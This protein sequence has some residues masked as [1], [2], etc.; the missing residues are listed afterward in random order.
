MHALRGSN[1]EAKVVR[2]LSQEANIILDRRVSHSS[3][4]VSVAADCCASRTSHGETHGAECST[5]PV[6]EREKLGRDWQAEAHTPTA[7]FS[8]RQIKR[9]E[10]ASQGRRRR[11]AGR[12]ARQSRAR[13]IDRSTRNTIRPRG[14]RLRTRDAEVR[15]I[16]TTADVMVV[17]ADG[18]KPV[19]AQ[20]R[21]EELTASILDTGGAVEPCA[22]EEQDHPRLGLGPFGQDPDDD[23]QGAPEDPIRTPTRTH[24]PGNRNSGALTMSHPYQPARLFIWPTHAL[25]CPSQPDR[26]LS[27][28]RSVGQKVDIR[29]LRLKHVEPS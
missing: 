2:R 11:T 3:M 18:P 10:A 24:G 4:R 13:I 21:C 8:S 29:G 7:W 28:S 15:E 20:Q 12:M 9:H 17:T 26:H 23:F 27:I 16:S 25:S 22:A 5:T 1:H 14:R 19:A 6:Q